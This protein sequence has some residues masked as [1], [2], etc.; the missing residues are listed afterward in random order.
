MHRTL[1]GTPISAADVCSYAG[2]ICHRPPSRLRYKFPPSGPGQGGSRPH[3]SQARPPKQ[4]QLT[5][6]LIVVAHKCPFMFNKSTFL[7]L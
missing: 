2:A 3:L 4:K 7:Y 1:E 6:L 5:E